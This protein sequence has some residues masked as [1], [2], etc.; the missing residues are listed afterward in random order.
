VDAWHNA[1]LDGV[2]L[3]PAS[4]ADDLVAITRGLVPEL[5]ERGL[6]RR[7][8]GGVVLRDHLGLGKPAN[9]YAA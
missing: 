7:S 4:A 3:R 5:Q 9:R 6:F 8:Y 1:G 2:R